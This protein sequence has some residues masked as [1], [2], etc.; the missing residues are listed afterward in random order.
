MLLEWGTSRAD[1]ASLECFVDGS[2][3]GQPVY[4]RAG[5]VVVKVFELDLRRFGVDHTLLGYGMIRP[6]KTL[7]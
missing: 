3:A 1:E 5:F 6:P 4:E 7:Q 2:T